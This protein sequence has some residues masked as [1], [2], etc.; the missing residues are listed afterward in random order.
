MRVRCPNGHRFNLIGRMMNL[1]L[2]RKVGFLQWEGKCLGCKKIYRFTVTGTLFSGSE[3]DQHDRN[4]RD[5]K[6]TES[7][8]QVDR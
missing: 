1:K 8:D 6:K 7:P 2:T 3:L 4:R 5:I